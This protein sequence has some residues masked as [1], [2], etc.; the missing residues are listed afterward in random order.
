MCA[1]VGLAGK[2]SA[3]WMLSH[4]SLRRMCWCLLE[5]PLAVKVMKC[6]LHVFFFDSL[7]G[8]VEMAKKK[9]KKIHFTFP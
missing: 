5:D 8:L 2:H 7:V 4:G 3:Y 1:A 9:G 6:S